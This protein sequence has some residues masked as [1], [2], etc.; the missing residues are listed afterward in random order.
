MQGGFRDRLARFMQGRYGMDEFGRFLNILTFVLIILSFFFRF[1][2][3]PS[4][5]LIVYEYFRILSRN[6]AKR[7]EENTWFCTYILRRRTGG[8]YYQKKSR[9]RT[10]SEHRIFKCP[11]CTQ[12]IRVPK[13]KG[14]ICIRCPKCRIEFVKKT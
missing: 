3:L 10:D 13:G 14:R 12:K 6:Y 2:L 7:S 4:V 11:N 5:L 1:L 8:N 9:T